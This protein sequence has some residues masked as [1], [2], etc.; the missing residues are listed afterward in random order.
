MGLCPALAEARECEGECRAFVLARSTTEL[1]TDEK[2][3]TF[4]SC[5][6]SLKAALQKVRL[7]SLALVS[8][9]FSFFLFSLSSRADTKVVASGLEGSKR[10]V[11]AEVV[12]LPF[13]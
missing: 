6:G 13:Q 1:L 12:L 5:F 7:L 4:T 11:C 8:F 9:F 3:Q 2:Q 10:L